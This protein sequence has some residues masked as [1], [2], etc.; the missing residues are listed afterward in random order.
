MFKVLEKWYL[1]KLYKSAIRVC[2]FTD[3]DH[4]M[5]IH[6]DTDGKTRVLCAG[7]P[8]DIVLNDMRDKFNETLRDIEKLQKLL[9]SLNEED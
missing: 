4:V 7:D 1:R 3:I 5:I 9:R 2:D 6:Q 8:S